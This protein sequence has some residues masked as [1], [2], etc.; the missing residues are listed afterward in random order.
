MRL[1]QMRMHREHDLFS[2]VRAGYREH[3]RVRGLH[4]PLLGA[5]ATG[6]DDFTVFA[7]GFADGVERLLDRSIDETTGVYDDQISAVVATR[8]LVALSAQARNNV[9]GIDSRLGT[10]E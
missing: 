6:H 2:R 9:F 4:H 3:L 1:G 5:Q 7:Q 8:N 10:A